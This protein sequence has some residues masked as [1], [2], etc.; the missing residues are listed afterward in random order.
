MKI[1][2]ENDKE[3][4]VISIPSKLSIPWKLLGGGNSMTAKQ[5]EPLIEE[6]ENP[7]AVVLKVRKAFGLEVLEAETPKATK[8]EK[9]R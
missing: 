4:M 5:R 3:E 1:V 7:E 9:G 8:A 6:F 2:K